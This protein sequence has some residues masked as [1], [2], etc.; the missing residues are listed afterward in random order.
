ME[1][2]VILTTWVPVQTCFILCDV[3][4]QNKYSNRSPEPWAPYSAWGVG[5]REVAALAPPTPP[6]PSPQLRPVPFPAQ[7][8]GP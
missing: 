6:F 2:Y 1:L 5:S 4:L 8:P 3:I 7:F